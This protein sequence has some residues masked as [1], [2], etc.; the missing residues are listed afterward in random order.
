[1]TK[2]TA[3]AIIA[4]LITPGCASG[5]QTQFQRIRN[6]DPVTGGYTTPGS[7][8]SSRYAPAIQQLPATRGAAS[9]SGATTTT[10]TNTATSPT[11]TGTPAVSNLK[12]APSY[13]GDDNMQPQDESDANNLAPLSQPSTMPPDTLSRPPLPT[14]N[15]NLVLP[16]LSNPV[17]RPSLSWRSKAYKLS[18]ESNDGQN[19]KHPNLMMNGSVQDSLNAL[20]Q[21]CQTNGL[22]IIGQSLPAGQL[23]ARLVDATAGRSL[24]VF[25]LKKVADDKTIVKA[26]VEP[27]SKGKKLI[28]LGD[29]LNQ[30]ASLVDGKGL[31]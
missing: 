18:L 12:S 30:A 28:L 25:V 3:L 9:V 15:E 27:D 29:L 10:T 24:F 7:A 8:A 22:Q 17:I 31:L 5:Q 16:Q 14:A 1:M 6:F 20:V 11:N 19:G 23:G 21:A 13:Q 2:R 26:C 4:I